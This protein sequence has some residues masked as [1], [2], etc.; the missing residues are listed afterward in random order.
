MIRKKKN[1]NLKE[2]HVIKSLK[3]MVIKKKKKKEDLLM[4]SQ[5]V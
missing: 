4:K 3:S 5:K 1:D 2:K